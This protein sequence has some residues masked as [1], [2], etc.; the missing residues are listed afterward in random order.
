MCSSCLLL[1]NS[2]YTDVP[3]LCIT[4]HIAGL[5]W[6]K[7]PPWFRSPSPLS[8]FFASWHNSSRGCSKNSV[9]TWCCFPFAL[10]FSILLPN[11]YSLLCVASFRPS[12]ICWLTSL[13][14]S[15]SV[16]ISN[17]PSSSI[18]PVPEKLFIIGTL[19]VFCWRLAMHR[20][21]HGIHTPMRIF[22]SDPTLACPPDWLFLLK[23]LPS[24]T[25]LPLTPLAT[26][27]IL[28][29]PG[30]SPISEFGKISICNWYIPSPLSCLRFPRAFCATSNLVFFLSAALLSLSSQPH[31]L[32]CFLTA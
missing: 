19:S 5:Y 2:S 24:H 20:A 21:P 18:L 4:A 6:V 11:F 29:P 26:P 30:S 25:C 8:D 28:L 16:D 12:K 7:T 15:P 31:N 1:S 17:H 10:L 23:N 3:H 13:P 22:F 14:F 9:M 27:G 32:V